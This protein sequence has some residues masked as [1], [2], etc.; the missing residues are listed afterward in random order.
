[1]SQ[2]HYLE[3]ILSKFNMADCKPKS[4]PCTGCAG[5]E[6]ENVDSSLLDDSKW[7][8]AIARRLICVMTGTM[9][10]ICYA[11]AKLSWNMAIHTESDLSMPNNV[12]TYL[13]GSIERERMFRRSELPIKLTGSCDS[14]KVHL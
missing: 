1:M 12:L 8:R 9:P 10:D 2:K 11:V 7:Y 5:K 6:S 14:D 4:I 13:K 3:K